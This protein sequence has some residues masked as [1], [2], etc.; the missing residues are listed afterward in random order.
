MM[1]D[2]GSQL[3]NSETATN[4]DAP[5]PDAAQAAEFD[6][7]LDNTFGDIDIMGV[8]YKHSEALLKTDPDRY[9]DSLLSF[10]R[11]G[12]AALP[13]PA[14]TS[15]T[16]PAPADP[17]EM[18]RSVVK[19]EFPTP[20]AL[21]FK[22][23]ESGTQER[24]QKLILLRDVW[25]SLIF[26][27]FGLLI[28]EFRCSGGS[29]ASTKLRRDIFFS[30]KIDARL[31]I[32]E[33][34]LEIS[35]GGTKPSLAC[36]NFITRTVIT[37]LQSLNDKRNDFSHRGGESAKQI[38]ER[39][40]NYTPIVYDLL[41]E[42]VSLRTVRLLVFT[43]SE[44]VVRLHHQ[45]FRGHNTDRAYSWVDMP[46]DKVSDFLPLLMTNNRVLAYIEGEGRMFSVAPFIHFADDD[47]GHHT[48]LCFFKSEG[49]TSRGNKGKLVFEIVGEALDEE[50]DES[51]FQIE[52]D[53][54]C[55][56]LAPQQPG[57][58]PQSVSSGGQAPQ[59][60]GVGQT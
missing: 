8:P 15:I 22:R 39:I 43:H 19:E 4:A 50:V 51:F 33:K 35:G 55:S 13:Q 11:E 21:T 37:T 34:V 53:D 7:W 17:V 44:N 48:R 52:I 40:E 45:I 10:V 14:L 5:T 29:F 28:G 20:V 54:L 32:M 16:S 36:A 2:A 30:D 25:E 60:V 1:G 6:A 42:V 47:T 9:K 41:S 31:T 27:L 58:Q 18:M 26:L 23:F 3:N 59:A 38:Q 49:K 24:V 57:G 56:R 12:E 46:S